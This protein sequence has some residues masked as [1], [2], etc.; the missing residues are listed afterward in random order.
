MPLITGISDRMIALELGH[1]IVEGTPAAGHQRSPCRLQSTS[2]ATWPPSTA[3]AAAPAPSAAPAK[4]ARP[5]PSRAAAGHVMPP[6]LRLRRG[7]RALAAI[8]LVAAGW[9]LASARRGAAS[10][11]PSTTSAGGPGSTRTDAPAACSRPR[12]RPRPAPGRGR[13]PEGATASAAL[14]WRRSPRARRNPVAHA[15]RS[16]WRSAAEP[17]VVILACQAAA[18]VDR[19]ARARI[20]GREAQPRLRPSASAAPR[21][22]RHHISFGWQPL[23]FGDAASTWCWSPAS[24]RRRR[25]APARRSASPFEV[26]RST[27]RSGVRRRRPPGRSGRRRPRLADGAVD[28]VDSPRRRR[29]HGDH[30][31]SPPLDLPS[32]PGGVV[33]PPPVGAALPEAAP[34]PPPDLAPSVPGAASRLRLGVA[35]AERTDR[36]RAAP[37]RGSRWLRGRT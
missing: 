15:A 5:T 10:D 2:A 27:F 1:P 34:A 21:R 35:V 22:G 24:R 37:P 26:R 4:S 17:A 30:G 31:S 33:S 19:R 28:V 12:R 25:G 18:R 14:R 23:Q 9:L 32:S 11:A 8:G 29:S 6:H 36:L 20:V 3:P 13:P 7:L 16:A